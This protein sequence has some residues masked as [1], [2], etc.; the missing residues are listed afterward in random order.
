M[1][2]ANQT[3]EPECPNCGHH[4]I[5]VIW[6]YAFATVASVDVEGG[7]TNNYVEDMS[8]ETFECTECGYANSAA[9]AFYPA[10]DPEA[11]EDCDPFND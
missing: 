10:D 1:K 8:G 4:R 5:V 9:V 7:W 6:D 2:T 3:R 11:D